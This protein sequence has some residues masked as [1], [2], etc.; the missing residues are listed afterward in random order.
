MLNSAGELLSNSQGNVIPAMAIVYAV[1]SPLNSVGVSVYQEMLFKV[2]FA[3]TTLHIS[4]CYSEFRREF[5][6]P[7]ILALPVWDDGAR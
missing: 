6:V 7:A 4:L 5:P 2:H 1:V 3:L